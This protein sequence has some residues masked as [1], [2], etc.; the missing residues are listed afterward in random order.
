MDRLFGS[1]LILFLGIQAVYFGMKFNGSAFRS[2]LWGFINN[3]HS[4]LTYGTFVVI[5]GV[6]LIFIVLPMLLTKQET[7]KKET[8]TPIS[9]Q[10]EQQ[11]IR[12]Q[13][14][15]EDKENQKR[16]IEEQQKLEEQ[17]KQ[18]AIKRRRERS[19]NAAAHDALDDF[20]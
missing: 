2:S 6:F 4:L 14:L 12:E 11:K 17:R 13:Q 16:Q 15:I 20:L 10:F 5:A 19:A 1:Y 3:V 8:A 9:E 7:T 18:E